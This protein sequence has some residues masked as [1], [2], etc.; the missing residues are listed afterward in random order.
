M[1]EIMNALLVLSLIIVGLSSIAAVL[2]WLCY[3][4]LAC[5]NIKGDLYRREF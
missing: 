5:E 4:K 2:G 1:E 3:K